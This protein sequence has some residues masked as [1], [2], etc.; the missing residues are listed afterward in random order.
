MV[1]AVDRKVPLYTVWYTP[2]PPANIHP[3]LTSISLRYLV[4]ETIEF[5]LSIFYNGKLISPYDTVENFWH[6]NYVN[7]LVKFS[8]MRPAVRIFTLHTDDGQ[9]T[10]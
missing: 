1:R 2:P 9:V 6:S 5:Y 7:S 10:D 3:T 8:E 4:S